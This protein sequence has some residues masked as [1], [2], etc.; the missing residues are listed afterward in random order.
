MRNIL[1][2]SMALMTL[3]AQITN[4]N[5]TT[6]EDANQNNQDTENNVVATQ[7][8]QDR[9]QTPLLTQDTI[10]A[11]TEPQI[12]PPTSVQRSI[13]LDSN[14]LSQLLLLKL[15]AIDEGTSDD[16]SGLLNFN[17]LLATRVAN[18]QGLLDTDFNWSDLIIGM[19]IEEGTNQFTL[20]DLNTNED[21]TVNQVEERLLAKLNRDTPVVDDQNRINVINTD[22][23]NQPNDNDTQIEDGVLPNADDNNNQ[24]TNNNQTNN[25]ND[26]L[27]VEVTVDNH[28]QEGNA[29]VT[30]NE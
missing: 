24:A 2:L 23:N 15:V 3:A 6:T 7:E 12:S 25:E 9:N 18:I 16:I 19:R 27:P 20:V 28:T 11:T 4:D 10:D 22:S 13:R 14:L 17:V 1:I 21:L 29:L 30:D 26:D 5:N 8:Q